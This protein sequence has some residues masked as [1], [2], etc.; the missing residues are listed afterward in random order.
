L[1][2]LEKNIL[3]E[4]N[5]KTICITGGTG[6][7]GLGLIKQL[8]KY[9]PKSIRILSNDEN[10]IF[11]AKNHLGKNPVFTFL[12]GDIRDK[13]RMIF[14]MKG[15]DIIF[16]VAAMKHVDICESDPFE[17]IKTNVV[18]TSNV[19]EV[20]LL[21][22]I[23]KVVFVST[24]KATNPTSTLGAS[25]LLGER[26]T[27]K[28]SSLKGKGKT[29]FLVVRFGNVIGSR[30]SVFQI[31]LNQ[32]K[33]NEPLTVTDPNMTRFI[34]S[35]SDAASTI[36]KATHKAKDGEIFILKMQS[37]KILDLAQEM[38]KVY[39]KKI[40]HAKINSKI[41]ISKIREGERMHEYLITAD[42]MNFCHNEGRFYKINQIA[43][44][45]RIND[46]ELGSE[47]AEKVTGVKLQ[48]I[49]E[50]LMNEFGI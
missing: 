41:I 28:A 29:N 36:L 7:I 9:K 14:A 20:A 26:L 19:L 6:S 12:I 13:D 17:T 5:G 4:F 23:S 34:M 16:H 27:I 45:K 25:K 8:I 37:V 11:E 35:I 3:N 10:S 40:P 46:K 33:K 22:N 43:N 24:D 38:I 31:F 1:K 2:A 49:I 21:Q 30:G 39:Q 47:T 15:V 32:I 42:E 44:K 48:K 18:G 50:E